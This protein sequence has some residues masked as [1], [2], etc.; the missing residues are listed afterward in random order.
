MEALSDIAWAGVLSTRQVC[1]IHFPSRRRAQRRL[2]ALLDHGL[3]R[4]HLQGEALHRENVYTLTSLGVDRLIERGAFPDGPPRPFRVPR[5]QK[6]AHA[7]AVREVF[8]A[9]RSAEREE[10]L[11][12]TDFR[13][14]EEL[15]GGWLGRDAGLIP[16]GLAV[17]ESGGSEQV[18][19]VEVDLGTETTTT[20]R[21]KLAAYR[22]AFEC[23]LGFLGSATTRLLVAAVSETRG[24]TLLRLSAE[25]G[26]GDRR[27]VVLLDGLPDFIRIWW[28]HEPSAPPGH[29]ERSA[30]GSEASESAA[31]SPVR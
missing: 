6:F 19:L 23:G 9:F 21:A 1:R 24:A 22:R 20:L 12:L 26:L 29:G 13:F 18:L 10:R 27:S 15:A 16:D 2:R 31:F 5:P 7:L 4:A 17:V 11:R 14:E 30:S 28:P 25:S 3:V 8:V